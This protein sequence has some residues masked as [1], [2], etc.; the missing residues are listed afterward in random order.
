M[1]GSQQ[2]KCAH[3]NYNWSWWGVLVVLIIIVILTIATIR[4]V[5]YQLVFYPDQQQAWFPQVQYRN[6]YIKVSSGAPSQ[7]GQMETC[8]GWYFREFPNR[9]TVLFFHGNAG[10][11]SH[12]SY[13]VSICQACQ[14]NLLLIDYRGYGQSTGFPS[15]T[16]IYQDGVAA[17]QYLNTH[18]K[19]PIDQ[20][21]VWGE[22]LGGTVATN[23]AKVFP[24]I[25]LLVLMSTFSCLRDILLYQDSFKG[26][27][28]QKKINNIIVRGF[29]WFIPLI[30]HPLPSKEL[31]KDVKAPII[32]YH[33]KEDR[34]IPY[35][36]AEIMK[37]SN[38]SAELIE[39]KGD[40]IYPEITPEQFTL[41]FQKANIS[42][43]IEKDHMN[44]LLSLIRRFFHDLGRRMLL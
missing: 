11:I 33:S 19:I 43:E 42:L 27:D 17:V 3:N 6:V 21:I 16:N 13:M 25:K 34:L 28:V 36:C 10:N 20:M 24:H 18:E 39:I 29:S 7:P 15:P 44:H 5:S 9:P 2:A 31:I 35:H 8:H 41:I 30:F 1:V 40:H 23:T 4:W 38:P 22:S 37:A 32:I 26:Q 14:L 12:R